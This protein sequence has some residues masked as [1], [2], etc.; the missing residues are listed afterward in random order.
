MAS[1]VDGFALLLSEP[2]DEAN[3]VSRPEEI[4]AKLKIKKSNKTN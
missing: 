2:E 4:Q 3:S 1:P